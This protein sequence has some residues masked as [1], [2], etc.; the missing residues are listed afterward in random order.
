MATFVVFGVVF[1]FF[2]FFKIFGVFSGDLWSW[3]F[4]GLSVLC[5]WDVCGLW[6]GSRWFFWCLRVLVFYVIL[7]DFVQLFLFLFGCS[8]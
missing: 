6:W 4:G 1:E 8:V 7:V 5:W 3:C 2:F